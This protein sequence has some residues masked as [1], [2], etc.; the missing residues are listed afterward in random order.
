[1]AF[2]INTEVVIDDNKKLFTW[3]ATGWKFFGMP[4]RGIVLGGY[5][6]SVSWYTVNKA[7][8]ATD[9]TSN[10]GDIM[11]KTAVYNP[12]MPSAT[13]AY[14]VGM[15]DTT[16]NSA[17]TDDIGKVDYT[18][19]TW[20]F[21][22][23]VMTR[24]RNHADTNIDETNQ[25]GYVFQGGHYDIDKCVFA[26]DT[27]SDT[28]TDGY[29][30]STH[31]AGTAHNGTLGHSYERDGGNA[32]NYTK[33]VFVTTTPSNL[34]LNVGRDRAKGMVVSE[35]YAYY[36]GGLNNTHTHSKVGYST[37]TLNQTAATY[38]TSFGGNY[39]GETNNCACPQSAWNFVLAGYNGVQNNIS[40]KFSS[41]TETT[42]RVSGLDM[43]GHDG[44]SSG[45][46][47]WGHA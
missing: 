21:F 42:T 5:K 31:G 44:A 47:N 3:G 20:A 15:N 40:G 7:T 25:I 29:G 10:L 9:T 32:G 24:N 46:S 43:I 45:H 18:T 19:E 17:D 35:D 34:S 33:F 13:H 27:W 38:P 30:N 28:G 2:K 39:Q 26:T 41:D 37:E 12:G 22:A 16:D 1:M 8:Y 23:G 6:D 14:G 36:F 4:T 11:S